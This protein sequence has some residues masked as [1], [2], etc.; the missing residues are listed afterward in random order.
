MDGWKN[1]GPPNPE[2]IASIMEAVSTQLPWMIKGILDSFFSPEAAANIAK[3]VAEF[4]KNLIEGGIPEDEAM[5]MTREYLSTL[6]NWSKIVREVR[7]SKWGHRE[8]E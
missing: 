1:H 3:A 7:G 4:R 2:D 8:E 5:S 6:T